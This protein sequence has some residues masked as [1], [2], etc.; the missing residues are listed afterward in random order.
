MSH[1]LGW[2]RLLRKGDVWHG[3]LSIRIYYTFIFNIRR[4]GV[5]VYNQIVKC[6]DVV[7][8]GSGSVEEKTNT[9]EAFSVA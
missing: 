3:E 9:H 4:G 1:R 2:S 5:G 6:Y 8:F 7:D